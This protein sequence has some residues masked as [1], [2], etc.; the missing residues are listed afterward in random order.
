MFTET[1]RT[2]MPMQHITPPEFR[3]DV[4]EHFLL[5]SHP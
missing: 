4:I 1:G 2:H 5:T 3:S